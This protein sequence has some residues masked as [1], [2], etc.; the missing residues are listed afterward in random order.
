MPVGAG[1]HQ[2]LQRSFDELGVPLC[3]VTFCVLDLETTGGNRNDDMITEIGAVKVRGG[4]RLGTFQTLVNP[5]KAIPPQI[6]V[7]TGLTN[8]LV[9]PA[10]RIESVLPSLLS[11]I[12]D[13]VIVAHNS[14]FD[15]G[16]IRAALRRADRPAWS[17]TVIDTVPLA[18]RLVRDEVPNCKLGTLASRY[19]FEHQPSHRALDDA[20]ATVDL[21][22]LLIERAAGLGVL[23]LDDLVALGKIGGHPNAAKLKQTAALPRTPGVYMFRDPADR[24]LYVGKATNLRQRVRSYFGSDDRRKIGP[25]L[26]EMKTVTH[27]ELPDPLT[28]EIVETRIIGTSMPRYNRR[29]TTAAKYCYVKLDT[30]SPWPRLSVVKNPAKTGVH[31][32]PLP[33]RKMAALVVDGLH[34]ALPLRRC[35]QRLARDHRPDPSAPVCSAAQL[36][37]A[38]CP[39]SGTADAREYAAC[40][41]QAKRAMFGDPA[42]VVDALRS[43]MTD[44]AGQQRF[45]EAAM[46]RDRLSAVLGAIRRTSLLRALGEIG[47]AEVT[48]GDT[49]WVVSAGRL[50]DVR[51]AGRLTAAL[52]IEALDV[53]ESG[54]PTPRVHADEALCLAKFFDKRAEQLHVSCSGAWSFPVHATTEIP[55]IPRAA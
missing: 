6:T 7:L 41:E 2:N 25:M 3:E 17:G 10:P 30:E 51:A 46:T 14:A 37:V 11:F 5:G 26:R 23:G 53:I 54:R 22:H 47:D 9:A 15:M 34:T 45:E 20:L 28:A 32:G 52:P 24:V 48:L 4:E 27:I 43:R 40:V 38:H 19:R 35:T 1:S 21:L 33:S 44:L 36:G 39:C 13:S 55:P 16:F 18:R 49:T 12:G 29:G 42:Y 50:V 31:L 8:S